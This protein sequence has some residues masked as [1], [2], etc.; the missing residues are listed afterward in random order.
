MVY[1]YATL[2]TGRKFGRITQKELNKKWSGKE[3]EFGWLCTERAEKG[4]EIM[5]NTDNDSFV[6]KAHNVF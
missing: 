1:T 4:A 2:P 5:G 3:A 6:S